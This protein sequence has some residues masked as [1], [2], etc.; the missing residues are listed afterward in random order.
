MI[1]NLAEV[2]VKYIKRTIVSI[3]LHV[4]DKIFHLQLH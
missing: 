3:V 4:V 1:A 2:A